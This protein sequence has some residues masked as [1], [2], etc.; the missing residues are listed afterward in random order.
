MW[1]IGGGGDPF[2]T[3]IFRVEG[4]IFRELIYFPRCFPRVSVCVCAGWSEMEG[5]G[6]RRSADSYGAN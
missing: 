5:G 1:K 4:S 6:V 3:P 2:S